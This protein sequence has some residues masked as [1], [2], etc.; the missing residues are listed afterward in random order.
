MRD[1]VDSFHV[2]AN[3][4]PLKKMSI[5]S[6]SKSPLRKKEYGANF[7]HKTLNAEDS[8]THREFTRSVEMVNRYN[9]HATPNKHN[10]AKNKSS[11]TIALNRRGRGSHM[12][13][14]DNLSELSGN[15][16]WDQIDK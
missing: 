14:S 2:P 8:Q 13:M 4:S 9:G 15:D 10:F 12:K 16:E 3:L 1:Y 11:A 7:V 6:I 5:N